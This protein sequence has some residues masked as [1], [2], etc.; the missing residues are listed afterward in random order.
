M[1][2]R[3]RQ[4]ITKILG[5]GIILLFAVCS[6]M[7]GASPYLMG[8]T[9]KAGPMKLVFTT[10]PQTGIQ[11]LACSGLVTLQN[12]TMG[13]VPTNVPG[14]LNVNL[15]SLGSV[16]FYSDSRCANPIQNISIQSG[17]NSVSFYFNADS[18]TSVSIGASAPGYLAVAQSE[19]LT[20]NPYI[21]T[22][23]AGSN[24]WSTGGNWS[25]GA[26]PATA[27]VAYFNGG[28][29]TYCSPTISTSLNI[30]G[31]RIA[32]SFSGSLS[33]AATVTL[34]TSGFVQ[35]GGT[36]NLGTSS[37]TTSGPFLLGGGTFNNTTG[38]VNV[39]TPAGSFIVAQPSTF[40]PGT[41]MLTIAGVTTLV[42]GSVVYNNVTLS[43][44]SGPMNM[45]GGSM[46]IA[47]NLTLSPTISASQ[48]NS[49]TLL[50]SGNLAGSSVYAI[51]GSAN[52]Q[53]LG[54]TNTT[55]SN[56]SNGFPGTSLTVNKSSGATVTL[57]SPLSYNS[58]G[59]TL[60]VLSGSVLLNGQA[61]TLAAL[62]LNGNTLT[63]GGGNLTVASTSIG[64]GSLFGGTIN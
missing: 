64:T 2:E 22:G 16:I 54:A 41:G 30:A 57:V 23:G 28:C 32:P 5:A 48:M 31:I 24:V 47:G 50:V 62:S 44:G 34:G 1:M 9:I 58:A 53:L 51:T 12:Q 4:N 26:A 21:W 8:S 46:N 29:S 63:K 3:A 38:S 13:G 7:A 10:A 60:S 33:V 11:Q 52:I 59:Q 37:L 20:T 43:P 27:Y 19:S 14:N 45:Y 36:F 17:T 35:Q 18:S 6:P 39:N 40:T 15:G 49:G 55:I 25:G 56:G 61:A 42:P